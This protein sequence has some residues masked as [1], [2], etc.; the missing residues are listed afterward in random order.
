MR[1]S[2]ARDIFFWEPFARGFSVADTRKPH[3]CRNCQTK[4]ATCKENAVRQNKELPPGT[5]S[6][7][8]FPQFRTQKPKI[9]KSSWQNVFLE[10]QKYTTDSHHKCL[11]R[12]QRSV[13]ISFRPRPGTKQPEST[14]GNSYQTNIV[15]PDAIIN[16]CGTVTQHASK[17]N[18]NIPGISFFISSVT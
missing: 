18:I 15:G 16:F 13:L 7:G 3:V 11:D 10:I 8:Y 1:M 6:G 14:L 9:H 17:Q 5:F 12:R 2:K 4:N